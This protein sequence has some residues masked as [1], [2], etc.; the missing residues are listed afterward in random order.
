[1][2]VILGL[3]RRE[4]AMIM[5]AVNACVALAVSFGLHLTATQTAAVA[6]IATGLL[7][8]ATGALTRPV[9]VSVITGGLAAALTAAVAFGLHLSGN[10]IGSL[11]TVLSLAL[12]LILRQNVSPAAGPAAQP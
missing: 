6:T 1:M 11:V 8:I 4:P 2:T 9:E 7:A 3:L 12:A 10:Q 5:Y